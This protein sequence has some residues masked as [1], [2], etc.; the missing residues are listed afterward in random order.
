MVFSQEQL[1]FEVQSSVS[2]RARNDAKANQRTG[3]LYLQFGVPAIAPPPRQGMLMAMGAIQEVLSLPVQ[4]LSP[5]PNMPAPVLGLMNRGNRI[6]WLVDL[7]LLLGI[8]RLEP[9]IQ[10][11]HVLV[12]RSGAFALG[13]AVA[14]V[15]SM[16][17]KANEDL[18]P[19]LSLAN[20]RFSPYVSHTTA[21]DG[22]NEAVAWVLKEQSIL[23]SPILD[24]MGI[25]S[26]PI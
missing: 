7:G 11:H 2:A 6:F 20:A 5:M 23:E 4:R 21:I 19:A 3:Q 13:L 22:A 12:L 14:D 25:S 8:S 10:Q 17:W 26:V 1:Q 18:Q 9:N 16:T 24:S 15:Q